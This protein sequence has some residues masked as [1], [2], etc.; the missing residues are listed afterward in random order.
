MP[1]LS[2]RQPLSC[3][4]GEQFVHVLKSIQRGIESARVLTGNSLPEK[5]WL[6]QQFAIGVNDV[7]RVPERMAHISDEGCTAPS[8]CVKLQAILLAG[9]CNPMWLTKHLPMLAKSRKVPLIIVGDDKKG[10]LR[11]GELVKLKTAIAIGV[12]ARGSAINR[13]TEGVLDGNKPNRG[14][15]LQVE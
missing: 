8:P 15:V 13:I 11:L 14:A 4:E 9:D 5:V 2:Q 7:T 3:Y 1:S 6:K 10:S 12:N